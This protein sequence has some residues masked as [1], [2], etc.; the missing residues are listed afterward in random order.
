MVPRLSQTNTWIVM[1]R[2]GQSHTNMELLS[3]AQELKLSK[4]K[5]LSP[6]CSSSIF[7]SLILMQGLLDET[8]HCDA[9]S[10]KKRESTEERQAF[11]CLSLGLPARN[12]Y[13]AFMPSDAQWQ[14]DRED[15]MTERM[16][17]LP[18]L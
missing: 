8:R 5:V 2:P 9:C 3:K 7:S 15:H 1:F 12:H 13:E 6:F 18:R 4:R 10:F 11:R 16:S 17:M 14:V